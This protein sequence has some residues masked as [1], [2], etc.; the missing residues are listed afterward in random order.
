MIEAA[1]VRVDGD[2]DYRRHAHGP[3]IHVSASSRKI[4][5]AWVRVDGD[6]VR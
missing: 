4:E 5:A 2:H 3:K 6:D 1:C